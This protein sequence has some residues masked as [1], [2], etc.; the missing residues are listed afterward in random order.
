I[1][2]FPTLQQD[3]NNKYNGNYLVLDVAS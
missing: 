3:N 2:Q 1:G